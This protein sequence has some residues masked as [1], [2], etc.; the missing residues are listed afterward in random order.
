MRV[1]EL[2]HK[3]KV[4]PLTP[5]IDDAPKTGNEFVDSYFGSLDSKEL[6]HAINLGVG[7]EV[8]VEH[9]RDQL[10]RLPGWNI[11]TDPSLRGPNP[12][13]FVT[14]F[15]LRL[16]NAW[17]PLHAL[18]ME[19]KKARTLD[20]GYYAFT[21]RT[22]VHAHVDCRCWTEQ[23]IR[24]MV[25]LYLLFE[26]ALYRF[27][28]GERQDNVFCIPLRRSNRL[29]SCETIP[30]Y[31]RGWEKYAGLNL[32]PLAE[33]GTI[34]FRHMAGTDDM[35]RVFLWLLLISRLHHA[36]TR[37]NRTTVVSAIDSLK[38]DS[39]YDLLAERIFG[40]LR[41]YLPLVGEEMDA[42]ASEAKLF[43]EN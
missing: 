3:V 14:P 16:G 43:S 24:S 2:F 25:Q 30:D 8:E 5:R 23:Q 33:Y 20:P 7:I 39:Y 32:K 31:V 36:A 27:A 28:G 21:E 1:W 29:G 38:S 35:E 40:P 37:W 11:Q 26:D 12:R 15:G 4:G 42:A 19:I 13:E 6:R 18:Q 41:R 10:A 34:E 22:S 17:K 9:G